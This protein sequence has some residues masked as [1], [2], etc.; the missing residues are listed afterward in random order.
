MAPNSSHGFT[1]TVRPRLFDSGYPP[2]TGSTLRLLNWRL[3]RRGRR[4]AFAALHGR[5][6]QILT[7]FEA[8]VLR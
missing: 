7:F 3:D 8:H 1:S 2:E 4:T 6:Q 5:H